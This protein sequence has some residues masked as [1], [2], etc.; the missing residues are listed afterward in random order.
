LAPCRQPP[1]S[2]SS[3]TCRGTT[4]GRRPDAGASTPW[5]VTQCSRGFGTNAHSRSIST[6][7][8][9]TTAVVPS[10]HRFFREHPIRPSL[11]STSR[12]SATAGRA[13]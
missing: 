12:D 1:A 10:R 11:S 2:N 3:T 9:I 7:F 4:F 8:V 5:Q 6:A 13:A